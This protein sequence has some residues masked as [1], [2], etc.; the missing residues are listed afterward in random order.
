MVLLPLLK[1]ESCYLL[2]RSRIKMLHSVQP[3]I[4]DCLSHAHFVVSSIVVVIAVLDK[5]DD[6]SKS[7]AIYFEVLMRFM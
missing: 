1:L 2:P 7:L 5:A 6:V 4:S 3:A